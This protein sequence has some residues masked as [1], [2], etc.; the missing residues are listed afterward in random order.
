MS[1]QPISIQ[2]LQML[3]NNYHVRQK[4]NGLINTSNK[5]FESKEE[6]PRGR[7]SEKLIKIAKAADKVTNALYELEKLINGE[8][9]ESETEPEY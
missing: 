2:A 1:S 4:W 8:E 3:L 9:S 7:P 5:L 6:N